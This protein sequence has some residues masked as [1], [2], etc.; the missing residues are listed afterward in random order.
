MFYSVTANM[1]RCLVEEEMI[2]SFCREVDESCALLGCYRASSGNF[3][4]GQPVGPIFQLS[5]IQE[6]EP[7]N[8]APIGYSGTSVI[9]QKSAVLEEGFNFR[10][11]L[12]FERGYTETPIF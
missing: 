8:T 11:M 7:S 2:S 6:D 9:A 1:R 12:T 5:I 10:N 4:S 3:L